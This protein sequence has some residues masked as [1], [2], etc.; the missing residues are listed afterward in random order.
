[1]FLQTV[2][3]ESSISL[4]LLK[5]CINSLSVSL[6]NEFLSNLKPSKSLLNQ[7][8]CTGVDAEIRTPRAP[9]HTCTG[10][11]AAPVLRHPAAQIWSNQYIHQ[12]TAI[13][14]ELFL[15]ILINIRIDLFWLDLM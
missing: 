7:L 8:T 11:A 9:L 1:M 4:L 6:L 12:M 15:I 3:G 5:S 10:V 14:Y 13:V 2:T